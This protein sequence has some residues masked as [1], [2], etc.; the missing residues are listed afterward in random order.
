[1]L[2]RIAVRGSIREEKV[3]Q[4]VAVYALLFGDVKQQNCDMAITALE[5]A[6]GASPAEQQEAIR[7]HFGSWREAVICLMVDI[8]AG[9]T[10]EDFK[11]VA[12]YLNASRLEVAEAKLRLLGQVDWLEQEPL[13]S[14]PADL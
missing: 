7:R 10:E 4:L 14:R 3:R 12:A 13:P 6:I 8:A 1:M 11:Q 5:Q 2:E 9:K